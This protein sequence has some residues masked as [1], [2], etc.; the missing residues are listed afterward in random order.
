M[1][2]LHEKQTAVPNIE[3]ILKKKFHKKSP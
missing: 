3:K 1:C 2:F